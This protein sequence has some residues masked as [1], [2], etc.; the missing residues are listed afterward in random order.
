MPRPEDDMRN[1]SVWLFTVF[2]GLLG[3][4]VLFGADE[5]PKFTIKE[6]MQKAHNGGLL[7]T[8]KDGKG[9]KADKDRLLELYTEL[10]K[11]RPPRGTEAAW[12]QK[13]DAIVAA[14]KELALAKNEAAVKPAIDKLSMA[15]DC[16]ACHSVH[17]RRMGQ[18]PKGEG[19]YSISEVM[20]EAH[21]GQPNERLIDK[22]WTGR[23]SK[24]DKEQLVDLYS[25][26]P[27]DKPVR[28]ELS[29]WKERTEA[30]LAAAKG[31][32]NGEKGA[33]AKLGRAANCVICHTAHRGQ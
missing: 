21:A 7:N 1:G 33:E 19:K 13:C 24:A 26:L 31:V 25:S 11:N 12:K 9:T 4:G 5:K 8:I 22:V 27:L 3:I 20:Q 32:A 14:A 18:A 30:L 17:R 29:E 28:G 16:Q 6:I 23:A 10:G 2:A 15:V